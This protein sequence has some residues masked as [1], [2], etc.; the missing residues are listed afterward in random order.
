MEPIY[1]RGGTMVAWLRN[2]V[3]YDRRLKPCAFIRDGQVFSNDGYCV[4]RLIR[5]PERSMVVSGP[6]IMR[7]ES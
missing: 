7:P 3:I 6:G 1:N 5:G 2:G 4:G